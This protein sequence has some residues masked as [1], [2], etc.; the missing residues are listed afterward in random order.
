MRLETPVDF[1]IADAAQSPLPVE[2][3]KELWIEVTV[4]PTGPPRPIALAV[5]QDASWKPLV[6]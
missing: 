2:P 6:F 3:G 1:Y 4:P 5:K